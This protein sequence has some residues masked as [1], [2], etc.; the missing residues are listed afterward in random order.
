MPVP[1]QDSD[2]RTDR[3]LESVFPPLNHGTTSASWNFAQKRCWTFHF[4]VS[5]PV[6]LTAPVVQYRAM[7][8]GDRGISGNLG[9]VYSIGCG[10]RSFGAGSN[11]PLSATP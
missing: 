10:Q 6:L 11:P 2:T 1:T 7:P 9:N 3:Y 5:G 8:H 4:R